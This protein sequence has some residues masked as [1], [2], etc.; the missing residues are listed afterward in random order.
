MG[1]SSGI[2]ATFSERFAK[3]GYDLI[4]VARR[5]DKLEELAS[6][7]RSMYQVHVEVLAADLSRSDSLRTMENRISEESSLEVLVNNAGFGGYKPFVELAPDT[8][9]ELINLKVL[10]V[11][12]LTRAALP[13]MIARGQGA[14][15]NVSSR[16][17]FSG[18]LGSSQLP[19][20]AT[21]AG[22]NAYIN[23]FTELLESELEGTGVRVQ[24]LCPGVVQ[25][26]FHEQVGIDPS[27]YPAAIV[28]SPEDVV[29]ASLTG[30]Q[31]GEVICVPAMEDTNL[32]RQI[33]ESEI[34][35][36]ESTRTGN[37]AA[38]YQPKD[39]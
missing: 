31:L 25:T 4:I 16:L 3:D 8:A 5:R 1:A 29:Q 12:R 9:E 30:L 22:V 21:Y 14:V 38:R 24:A 10:A 15:I 6:R 28:M 35:F 13:G 19:K 23:T 33:Q 11:T 32:L 27:R 26:G 37:M 34:R 2:G 17:A 18:P 36:F 20:R 7:L 39:S